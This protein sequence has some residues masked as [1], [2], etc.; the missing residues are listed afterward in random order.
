MNTGISQSTLFPIEY[1]KNIYFQSSTHPIR[2]DY[3]ISNAIIMTSLL[4][5]WMEF[6]LK[7]GTTGIILTRLRFSAMLMGLF[8][9][10]WNHKC[11]QAFI[12]SYFVPSDC[13]F[14]IR[15][16]SLEF[17]FN[18][19]MESPSFF[20]YQPH[21][22]RYHGTCIAAC[23]RNKLLGSKNLTVF[24]VSMEDPLTSTIGLHSKDEHEIHTMTPFSVLHH[25]DFA[26]V[27]GL[28]CFQTM[29]EWFWFSYGNFG[30]QPEGLCQSQPFVFSRR[31]EAETYIYT[32]RRV[33]RTNIM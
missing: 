26:F 24:A 12:N 6:Q 14:L 15:K 3:R 19:S 4:H 7:S 2:G 16:L 5:L 33:L 21:V 10:F 20:F 11:D 1:A 18:N 17:R 29:A 9:D 22:E 30:L 8:I 23:T 27:F 31:R 13:F 25:T 28:S 32:T